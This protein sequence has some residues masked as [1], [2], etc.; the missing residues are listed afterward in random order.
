MPVEPSLE[1]LRRQVAS[2][3]RWTQLRMPA[4]SSHA[5]NRDQLERH[6]AQTLEKLRQADPGKRTPHATVR[7]ALSSWIRDVSVASG[8]PLE[9]AVGPEALGRYERALQKLDPAERE[10]LLAR[11][12]LAFTYRAVALSLGSQTAEAARQAVRHAIVHLALL[13]NDDAV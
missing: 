11:I 7:E 12:E 10:A 9:S 3:T 2:L 4:S 8:S 5:A 13:M 1:P 6:V